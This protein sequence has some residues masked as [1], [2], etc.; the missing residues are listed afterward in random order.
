MI[1][2]RVPALGEIVGWHE[3]FPRDENVHHHAPNESQLL[4]A[5][6]IK[7]IGGGGQSASAKDKTAVSSG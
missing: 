2:S 6:E 3:A 1:S 4:D 5:S 7:N